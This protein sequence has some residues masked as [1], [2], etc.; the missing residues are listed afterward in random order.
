MATAQTVPVQ[1]SEP[2]LRACHCC[3]LIQI[4]PHPSPHELV[5]CARCAT[6]FAQRGNQSWTVAAALSALILYPLAMSLPVMSI[7][8]FGVSNQTDIWHGTINLVRDGHWLIGGIVL[9]CSIVVP[10][11]KLMGLLWLSLA[12]RATRSH[13]R[14]L[15]YRLIEGAGRWGMIDVMLVAGVVAAVKLGDMVSVDAGPG[16]AIYATMVIMS[17]IAGATFDP[18]AMWRDDAFVGVLDDERVANHA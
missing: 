9:V 10:L 18:Q 7:E 3:G 6:P 5:T 17:L 11:M 12:S 15:T 1:P 4:V 16:A 14:A 13:H 2:L 8:R